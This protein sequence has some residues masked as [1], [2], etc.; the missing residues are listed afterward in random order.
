MLTIKRPGT[1]ILAYRLNEVVGTVAK[2]AIE[3]DV[4]ISPEDLA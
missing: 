3:H 2:R 4:P 1:G